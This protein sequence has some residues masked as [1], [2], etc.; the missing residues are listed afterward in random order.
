MFKVRS[1][2]VVPPEQNSEGMYQLDD[3]PSALAEAAELAGQ[4]RLGI[5]IKSAVLPGPGPR[6]LPD[7][8]SAADWGRWFW[9][10]P[11]PR[12]L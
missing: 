4:G 10:C 1:K 12:P 7:A 11:L 8:H 6:R 2:P 3:I 5:P 9:T